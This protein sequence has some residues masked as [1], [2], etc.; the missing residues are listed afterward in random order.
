MPSILF[1]MLADNLTNVSRMTTDQAERLR[2]AVKIDRGVVDDLVVAERAMRESLDFLTD[3]RQKA[4]ANLGHKMELGEE[5]EGLANKVANVATVGKNL[6]IYATAHT[7][8]IL[9]VLEL[10]DPPTLKAA[11]DR[12]EEKRRAVLRE[13]LK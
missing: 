10:V 8:T 11:W 5:L 7:E 4:E 9:K 12:L 13:A 1:N 2:H 6:S 3:T